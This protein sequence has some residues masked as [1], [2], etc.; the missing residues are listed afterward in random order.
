LRPMRSS[1]FI[2]KIGKGAQ[3]FTW[4]INHTIPTV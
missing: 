4:W 2:L 1:F 3:N